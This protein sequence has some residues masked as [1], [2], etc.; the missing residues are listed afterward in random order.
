M[1]RILALMLLVSTILIGCAAEPTA[2]PTPVPEQPT[3]AAPTEAATTTPEP[4]ATDV[5]TVAP[6]DTPQPTSTP[7]PITGAVGP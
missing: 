2:T 3:V 7:T 4:T 1:Y 6:T 5:P